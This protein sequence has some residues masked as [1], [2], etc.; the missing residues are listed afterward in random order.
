M[1]R[2]IDKMIA[3]AA[4]ADERYSP[5]ELES[6]ADAAQ[7]CPECDGRGEPLGMLGNILHLRCRNCGIDFQM[8]DPDDPDDQED[9]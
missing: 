1:N 8:N 7:A 9:E 2:P 5:D 6:H 3:D 4:E